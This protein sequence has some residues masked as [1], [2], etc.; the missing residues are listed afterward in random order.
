M[1]PGREGFLKEGTKKQELMEK[2]DKVDHPKI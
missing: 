1:I 2:I